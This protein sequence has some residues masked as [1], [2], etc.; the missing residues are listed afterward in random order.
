MGA[1]QQERPFAGNPK[2]SEKVSKAMTD[3]KNDTL[4]KDG[5]KSSEEGRR[6]SEQLVAIW[7]GLK[8]GNGLP[9]ECE[10]DID[11]LGDLLPHCFIIEVENESEYRYGYLGDA[12]MEAFADDFAG[13]DVYTHL[14]SPFTRDLLE[15]FHRVKLSGAPLI[16]DSEIVNAKG[17]LIRFRQSLVPLAR[18]DGKFGYIV[19]VMKWRSYRVYGR[20]D[21]KR[22]RTGR[23]IKEEDF[24]GLPKPAKR[25]GKDFSIIEGMDGDEDE[26][27]E[28]VLKEME[29]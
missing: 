21:R 2:G 18:I 19:G 28:L 7:E 23:G 11:A 4:G 13:K 26:W 12:I 5:E 25:Q 29:K 15:K 10:F 3:Q 8:Q 1:D 6:A 24:K 17:I 16:D 20:E 27:A 9:L 22:F 14:I